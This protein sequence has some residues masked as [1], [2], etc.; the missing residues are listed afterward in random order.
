MK[1]TKTLVYQ[2]FALKFALIDFLSL[3][4]ELFADVLIP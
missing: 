3:A 4:A 1:K 2:V